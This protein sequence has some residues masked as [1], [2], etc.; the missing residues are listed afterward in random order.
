M[1]I[2][3]KILSFG[4]IIGALSS[5]GCSSK[6]TSQNIDT[7]KSQEAVL[8]KTTQLNN[9]KLELEK[10]LVRQIQLTKDVESINR[11]ASA[12]SSDA[13]ELSGRVSR[14]PGESGMANRSNRASQQAAKDAKRA[15]KLNNQL[16][17]VNN[18]IKGLQRKTEQTER[19]LNDLK[20]KVE[21]VPNN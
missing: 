13:Q 3:S 5:I 10:N 18:K 21:F 12:S 7:L 16:D 15:K 17:N 9:Y 11:E 19:D 6:V 20:S 1:K 4:L 14:N 8:K 2:F